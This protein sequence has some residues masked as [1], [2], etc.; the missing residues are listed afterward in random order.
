MHESH[1]LTRL[2]FWCPQDIPSGLVIFSDITR[3]LL[4]ES[5]EAE[6]GAEKTICVEGRTFGICLP[7]FG[8]RER[9]KR[10]RKKLSW[11]LYMERH[12]PRVSF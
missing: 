1:G 6:R 10:E 5:M 9:L 11:A 12:A 4:C 3:S 8:V 2:L 7:R